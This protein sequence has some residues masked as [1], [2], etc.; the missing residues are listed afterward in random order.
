MRTIYILLGRYCWE[1]HQQPDPELLLTLPNSEIPLATPTP[2]PVSV[3]VLVPQAASSPYRVPSSDPVEHTN[4][5]LPQESHPRKVFH[6]R[7][8]DPIGDGRDGY[9][10]MDGHGRG[11]GSRGGGMDG[12]LSGDMDEDVLVEV[13]LGRGGVASEVGLLRWRVG[14]RGSGRGGLTRVEETL[15][16]MVGWLSIDERRTPVV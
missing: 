7:V 14:S 16:W 6:R 12:C 3:L 2:A 5:H 1:F 10:S 4:T 11:R 9:S 15:L 8:D 13:E